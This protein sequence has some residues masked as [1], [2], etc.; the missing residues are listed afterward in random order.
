LAFDLARKS[1]QLD[2][3]VNHTPFHMM[4]P[5]QLQQFGNLTAEISGLKAELYH[6][7]VMDHDV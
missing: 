5:Q 1:Y 6:L 4:N 7:M 2:Q 3:L